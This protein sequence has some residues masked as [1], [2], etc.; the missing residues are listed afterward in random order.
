MITDEQNV[1]KIS[2]R[3]EMALEEASPFL[4]RRPR[5][6][7]L[8]PELRRMVS[9]HQLTTADIIAPLFVKE[10]KGEKEAIASMPGVFRLSLDYLIK[11]VEGLMRNGVG[12]VDLFAVVPQEKK[13]SLGSESFNAQ[14]L[15]QQAV[16]TLKAEFPTLCV[17]ADVAL[18][19]FSSHGHD[20]ILGENGEVAN[21]PTLLALG[22]MS[23]S[24]AEAGVDLIAPSDMMDGRVGYL[25]RLLDLQGFSN[26]GILSYTAKYASAFYGPFRDA[27]HSAPKKGD[28]KGY[29]MN[30]AN[31][32]EALLET[33]LDEAEGADL[34]L[35][36]PG[37]AYLDVLAKI[38]EASHLPVGAY[39]VSG[40]YAMIEAAGERGWIDRDAVM[41][42][43]LLCFKRAGADFIFT[44]AAPQVAD[45]VKRFSS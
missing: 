35:V 32:R 6:N 23:L 10:G 20:G 26:V 36:K 13:D 22:K 41:Y 43:S 11:E 8:Q 9:E 21:D 4:H 42:E 3:E 39:Q 34:L 38:K 29:Q 45:L 25:R 12:V 40:E 37:I 30:P 15:L 1:A 2:I 7:R 44:Y 16:S 27:L 17:M 5:R 19:P 28:K 14:G 24:L 33:A 18:D 31:I